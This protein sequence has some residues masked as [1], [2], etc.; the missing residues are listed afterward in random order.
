MTPAVSGRDQAAARH[1][2]HFVTHTPLVDELSA[3][4]RLALAQTSRELFAVLRAQGGLRA[5]SAA[6][7]RARF[8]TNRPVEH[9]RLPP[10]RATYDSDIFA[11]STLSL[12]CSNLFLAVG[13]QG[14]I[15]VHNLREPQGPAPC[16]PSDGVAAWSPVEDLLLTQ[17]GTC[18]YIIAPQ[19][20]A[21]Y[22]NISVAQHVLTQTQSGHWL[23]AP[24][25]AAWVDS[26]D[27]IVTCEYPGALVGIRPDNSHKRSIWAAGAKDAPVKRFMVSPSGAR[28][29]VETDD[30]AVL[31]A[32]HTGAALLCAAPK[33][34][35]NL[36]WVDHERAIAFCTRQGAMVVNAMDGTLRHQITTG[37]D[38][39]LGEVAPTGST[40]AVARP[41]FFD[42]RVCVSRAGRVGHVVRHVKR[43]GG[44][45]GYSS[46][47]TLGNIAW[48][49]DGRRLVTY[50]NKRFLH[51][52]DI[53]R[54][55]HSDTVWDRHSTWA[56]SPTGA[57]LA[58][59]APGDSATSATLQVHDCD[60]RLVWS[61]PTPSEP[62]GLTWSDDERSLAYFLRTGACE[63]LHF[64]RRSA[65]AQAVSQSGEPAPA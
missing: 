44:Y 65:L 58:M 36:R 12:S 24:S 11:A 8:I 46:Y 35:C 10:P 29:F 6:L 1:L 55:W 50:S 33:V 16:Y 14:G 20:Q 31:V 62:L 19:P 17:A 37:I 60:G 63:V 43:L 49:N 4:D 48:S 22:Q 23:R 45:T 3:Q 54:D 57:W 30:R 18:L 59:G 9:V 21:A 25:H 2:A 61:R 38:W 27:Q 40:I 28:V 7:A 26:G 56:W 51:L 32:T 39:P 15:T 64:V 5:A 52:V 47:Y 13:L 42:G 41:D 53:E 34:F